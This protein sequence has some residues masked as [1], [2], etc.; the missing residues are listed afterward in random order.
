MGEQNRSQVDDVH[1]AKYFTKFV[2]DTID[3]VRTTT[4]STPLQDVPVTAKKAI[5]NWT[6]VMSEQNENLI[7]SVLSK[8]CQLDPAPIWLVQTH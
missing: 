5:N 7:G 3:A 1:A 4:F 8:T 6:L 2:T